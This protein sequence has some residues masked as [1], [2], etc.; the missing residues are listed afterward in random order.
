M[1]KLTN[2]YISKSRIPFRANGK[3]IPGDTLIGTLFKR[4]KWNN[5][6]KPTLG[7]FGSYYPN[8][9]I[10]EI[11]LVHPNHKMYITPVGQNNPLD[12]FRFSNSKWSSFWEYREQ[13]YLF[14]IIN[15]NE[16][17]QLLIQ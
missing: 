17:P 15:I 8:Q 5:Y 10:F 12:Y 1:N 7:T 9:G 11:D 6:R 14:Q 3:I 16:E 2:M 4:T 13:G